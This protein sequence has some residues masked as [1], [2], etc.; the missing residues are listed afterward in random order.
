M[1]NRD[2]NMFGNHFRILNARIFQSV[3]SVWTVLQLIIDN[4]QVLTDTLTKYFQDIF[5]ILLFWNI[6]KFPP[7]HS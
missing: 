5:H 3:E 2:S 1:Q 7:Y 4:L 6:F